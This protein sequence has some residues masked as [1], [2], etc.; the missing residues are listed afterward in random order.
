MIERAQEFTNQSATPQDKL[1]PMNAFSPSRSAR[2]RSWKFRTRV[3]AGKCCLLVPLA[4]VRAHE[5]TT[6][7]ATT[8]DR[9]MAIDAPLLSLGVE[10]P[11]WKLFL[12]VGA[13]MLP[14]PVS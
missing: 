9:L 12:V 3:V 11:S 5:S 6:L 7:S 13:R 1:M 4:Y 8:W 14:I 2:T 10:I